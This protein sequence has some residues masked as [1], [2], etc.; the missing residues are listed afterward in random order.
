MNL[1]SRRGS[2]RSSLTRDCGTCLS[3]LHIPTGVFSFS[4][5]E[6]PPWLLHVTWI[7]YTTSMPTWQA[8]I[9]GDAF[10]ASVSHPTMVKCATND[11]L[12]TP[13]YFDRIV[14]KLETQIISHRR[15]LHPILSRMGSCFAKYRPSNI[16]S[17]WSK[18]ELRWVLSATTRYSWHTREILY[19]ISSKQG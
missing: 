13:S 18:L 14:A 15:S 5:V 19:Q 7:G 3:H 8:S 16:S 2:T 4:L 1:K 11:I 10:G 9:T 12:K 17:T 6:D